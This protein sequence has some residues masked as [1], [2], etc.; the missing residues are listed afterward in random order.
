MNVLIKNSFWTQKGCAFDRCQDSEASFES[1]SFKAPGAICRPVYNGMPGNKRIGCL[2][3]YAGPWR[4]CDTTED[5]C[6]GFCLRMP[7]LSC[8]PVSKAAKENGSSINAFWKPSCR[9]ASQR[10]DQEPKIFRRI[11]LLLNSLTLLRSIWGFHAMTTFSC[12]FDSQ[13]PDREPKIFRR[14]KLQCEFSPDD[15]VTRQVSCAP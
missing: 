11:E 8:S 5:P 9:F 2:S 13:R 10:P 14:I 1:T 12:R 6:P 15:F 3:S 4:G 7:I